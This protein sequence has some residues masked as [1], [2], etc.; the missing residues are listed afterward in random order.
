MISRTSPSGSALLRLTKLIA[1]CLLLLPLAR[2]GAADLNVA[3]DSASDVP[4]VRPGDYDTAGRSLGITLKF[5]PPA[6]TNLTVVKLTG[7]GTINGTFSNLAQNQSITLD[8]A[9]QSFQF[10]AN[11]YGGTG[12][13]LVLQWAGTRAAA[14]GL[15]SSGQLGNGSFSTSTLPAS[16][17]ATGVLSGKTIIALAAGKGHSLALCSDGTLAGWGVNSSGQIGSNGGGGSTTPVLISSLG[18]LSSK[19]VIAIAAGDSH[20]LALCSDGTVAAWGLNS[21]GQLGND[22]TGPTGTPVATSNFGALAGQRAVAIAAGQFHSMALRS[23]GTVVA[24]GDNGKGQLGIGSNTNSL[25]AATVSTAGVLSGKSVAA[26]AAGQGHSMALCSDGTLATWGANADGQ[27]GNNSTAL[28]NEPVAVTIAG[29]FL[30]TRTVTAIAAGGFHSLA[31]CS[32][33]KIAAWGQNTYGQLGITSGSPLLPAGVS[34]TGALLNKSVTAI[35]G[36]SVHSLALCSDGT[37]TAWGRNASGELGTGNF[38]LSGVPVAVN[39]TTLTAGERFQVPATGAN[40]VHTLAIAARPLLFNQLTTGT[41][42]SNGSFES[43]FTGWSVS[44]INSPGVP[45]SPALSGY[46]PNPSFGFAVTTPTDGTHAAVSGF[47]GNGPGIVRFAHDVA[48]TAAEPWVRFDYR[49]GWNM[50]DYSGSTKAR[51]FSVTIEP[52]GGGPVMQSTVILSAAAHTKTLDT[53]ALVGAVDLSAYIGTTVR[54]CFDLIIPENHTGPGFF[55]LDNVRTASLFPASSNPITGTATGITLSGATLNGTVNANGSAITVEYEFGT[56]TAYGGVIT[57]PQSPYMGNSDTVSSAAVSGLGGN[58]LYHYRVK[59]FD[60]ATTKYGADAT[61]TTLPHAPAI[62]DF[63]TSAVTGSS[64]SFYTTVFTDGEATTVSF[65]YGTDTNYGSSTPAWQSPLTTPGTTYGQISGLTGGVTYH[66]RVKT[67][68]AGG[69]TYSS[70]STFTPDPPAPGTPAVNTLVP[71][72]V[73]RNSAMLN[74]TVNANGS[75]ATVDFQFGT[76]TNYNSAVSAFPSPVGGSTATAIATTKG[77]LSPGTTY[78]YRTRS[79]ASGTY[80]YGPDVTFTTPAIGFP[81]ASTSAATD[82]TQTTAVLRGFASANNGPVTTVSFEYGLDTNYGS[83]AAVTPFLT[84]SG[85]DA[86]QAQI[87]VTGDSVTYHYRIKATNNIGTTYGQ[88]MTFTTPDPHEARLYALTFETGAL[89]PAFDRNVT[90]YTMSLPFETTALIPT[91]TASTGIASVLVNGVSVNSGVPASPIPLNIGSNT[92]TVTVTSLDGAVQQTY[93][94]TVTRAAPVAGNFDL[95]F[96]TGGMLLTNIGASYDNAYAVLILPDGRILA[97]GA[98]Y[99]GNDYDFS[100]ARFNPDGTPDTTFNG[101]GTVMTDSGNGGDAIAAMALQ[102]DGKIVVAGTSYGGSGNLFAVARYNP[103]GSLDATFNGT[104]KFTAQ[105]GTGDCGATALAIQ[106]DGKIV[107]AGYAN[108]GAEYDFAI[109]RIHGKATTGAP[110]TLDTSFNTTGKVISDLGGTDD[111]I[112]ALAMQGDGKIVVAGPTNNAGTISAAVARYLTDGSPD[113]GFNG[114]G[115]LVTAVIANGENTPGTLA[116]QADGKIIVAGLAYNGT[117]NDFALFRVHGDPAT[118]A[119]G[120]LDTAFNGT[121]KVATD[122]GGG[123]DAIRAIALQPDGKIVAAGSTS[124]PG[125]AKIAVARYHTDGSLDTTFLGTGMT[126]ADYGLGDSFGS[127]LAL[128]EDGKIVVA[129]YYTAGFFDDFVLVR[130]LGDGPAITVQTADGTAVFDQLSTLDLRGALPGATPP[131]SSTT[132]SSCASSATAPP[133]PCRPPMAPPSST[134]SRRSTSAARSPARTAPPR[135]P[136]ATPAPRPSPASAS[137]SMEPTAPHSPSPPI[138]PRPSRPGAAPPSPCA[139]SP[140]A[141]AQ[142]PPRSTSRQTSPA[143]PTATTSPSPAPASRPWKTGASSSSATSPTPATPPTTPTPTAPASRTSPS[144]ASSA[145][146]RIPRSPSPASS[147]SR[148]SSATAT[149]SPSPSPTASAP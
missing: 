89:S 104:G 136:S 85:F 78:H 82:I 103:D 65:E 142:R 124:Q 57:D 35:A 133:S 116:I 40:A 69:I 58:T 33:G 111:F 125:H 126:T 66:W 73:N 101:N 128:Q 20:S 80:T 109:L 144:S 139:S 88:D 100:L 64:A 112:S 42:I 63:G 102:P 22:L 105:V 93:T 84:S 81:A 115:R 98:S 67:E 114:T 145:P 39:T 134:S 9:G 94:V 130:L 86:L 149:S 34:T 30:Q 117:S 27:L 143:T 29:T 77:Q 147:P 108:N 23:D 106:A 146:A 141:S 99:N 79:L 3:Y 17:T 7:L 123:N 13:D 19:R 36:G 92:L 121:G 95:S 47:D 68:N 129:G 132:S 54:V 96:A 8:Y 56:T 41:L 91:P 24:W 14:W 127:A 2:A 21:S 38:S 37:L 118:G 51:T 18:A 11:Y 49:A 48:V 119:P 28:S 1:L 97:A 4:V 148:R 107:A 72:M 16:V 90:A 44:D 26:I 71:T 59:T 50:L 70:D 53:G 75:D 25:V 110:G 12:N 61:F 122:I 55:Q 87:P 32:D 31:L 138:P 10:T 5:A 15:N 83:I 76:T 43:G 113:T 74:G 6:G 140:A 135:S 137:P 120:T 60:G 131:A 46:N 52:A 45:I 62:S